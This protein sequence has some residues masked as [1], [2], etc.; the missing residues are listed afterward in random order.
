MK[1]V[2]VTS[3]NRSDN[4]P[5]YLFF[6]SDRIFQSCRSLDPVIRCFLGILALF[7]LFPGGV[8]AATYYFDYAS[9]SDSNSG[10]SKSSPWKHH[11][12]M[13]GWSGNYSHS[14]GDHFIFKGGVTWP[15]SN[16]PV[17]IQNG[18]ASSNPDYYGVDQSWY[19]GS[20]WTRPVMDGG[21]VSD[22]LFQLGSLSNITIDNLELKR[23]TCTGNFGSGLIDGGAVSNILIKNCYLH[24]WRVATSTDDAH[25]GVLFTQ[26]T[27]S[28]ITSVVID[29]CEIENSEN[30]SAWNGVC[31]RF[32]GTIRNS[33]IHDNS[34]AVLFC[35]DFD[36]SELYNIC[37]PNSG[38]DG[39][40]HFNGIYLGPGTLGQSVGYIRNSYLHDVGG[41]ANM[42]Y[43]NPAGTTVYI[44]NN[45]MYGK[46]SAQQA[47]EIDPYNYGSGGSTGVVYAYNN[48]VVVDPSNYTA[49]H[50]VNRG[51]NPALN[52]L[53]AENNLVIGSAT[54]TDGNSTTVTNLTQ[55]HNLVES[56]LQA[57]SLG[58]VLGNLYAATTSNSPSVN[59]GTDAPATLFNTDILGVNRPQ[60]GAW[61]IG[62]Y[63]FTSTSTAPQA[64]QNLRIV[65]P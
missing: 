62:A 12:Y 20:A 28:G 17:S 11:P 57:S 19:T 64:P 5:Q 9:G 63:E 38:F 49:I 22:D 45:V 6:W 46:M 23:I 52:T 58:F 59:A 41:G 2:C 54:V 51:G 40:Y 13:P 35:L 53:V 30:S 65:S 8:W 44:Y 39:T 36:H 3:R 31:A 33:K 32:V 24:G 56:V 18:G 61:D 29:T 47:I 50:V 1:S 34:S 16:F 15:S 26:Y 55:N 14:S 42:A 21:Y 10:T 25:G 48:T 43:P 27:A 37:T 4:Q 7:A 60:G